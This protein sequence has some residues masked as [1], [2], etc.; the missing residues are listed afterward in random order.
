LGA[1]TQPTQLSGN[2]QISYQATP[3]VQLVLTM[4]NLYN[5]CFGGSNEPWNTGKPTCGYFFPPLPYVGNFYNPG[6]AIQTG[7]QYP[8]GPAFGSVFQQAYQAQSNPFEAFL[9]VHVKL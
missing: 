9:A 6:N 3:R 8:Y 7:A 5:G 1:F 2:L 4:V